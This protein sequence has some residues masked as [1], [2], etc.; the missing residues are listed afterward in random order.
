MDIDRMENEK[1][2][3]NENRLMH[4]ALRGLKSFFK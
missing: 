2:K 3:K 1:K 4:Y